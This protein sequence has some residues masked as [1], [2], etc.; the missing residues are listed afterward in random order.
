[1]SVVTRT[2]YLSCH[3]VTYLAIQGMYSV[4]DKLYYS[5]WVPVCQTFPLRLLRLLPLP[6]LDLF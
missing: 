4:T 6:R 5:A 1:M 3:S 2:Y